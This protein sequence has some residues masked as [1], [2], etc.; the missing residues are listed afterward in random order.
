[1]RWGLGV[2]VNGFDN[3]VTSPNE[4]HLVSYSLYKKES[5]V[6]GSNLLKMCHFSLF[7]LRCVKTIKLRFTVM[8][9]IIIVIM[10]VLTLQFGLG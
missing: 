6:I 10:R 2:N 5:K 1:M 4:V 3:L 9:I 8:S 7:V